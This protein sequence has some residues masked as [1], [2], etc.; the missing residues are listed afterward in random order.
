MQAVALIIGVPMLFNNDVVRLF[1]THMYY[2]I[3]GSAVQPNLITVNINTPT[4]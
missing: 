1:C 2:S 4:D 3:K